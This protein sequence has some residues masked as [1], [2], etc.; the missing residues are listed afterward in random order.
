M[1]LIGLSLGVSLLQGRPA[2]SIGIAL[3]SG[4]SSSVVVAVGNQLAVDVTVS[5]LTAGGLPS[6]QSFELDITFDDSILGFVDASFGTA[7]NGGDPSKSFQDSG[8]RPLGVQA[9]FAEVSF[10]SDL[11]QQPG[12]FRIGTL[13]FEVI[14]TGSIALDVG[15]NV[16]PAS[17]LFLSPPS[18]NLLIDEV[19]V[20][21]IQ[22][23]PEPGSAALIALGLLGL[24]LRR[25]GP[26]PR[27]TDAV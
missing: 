5:G 16:S 23:V 12:S 8:L 18:T 10:L 19:T 6:L 7:L 27:E 1:L 25:A 11:Q 14:G 26:G 2:T 17:P 4:E 20:L 13:L 21:Q 22:A 15:T 9:F 24:G 3:T